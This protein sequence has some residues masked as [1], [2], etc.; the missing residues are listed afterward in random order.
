ML[1]KVT[2][3]EQKNGKLICL[4][5]VPASGKS[6]LI[7]TE[8]LDNYK[9]ACYV[10]LEMSYDVLVERHGETSI[11]QLD[12][13]IGTTTTEEIDALAKDYTVIVIDHIQL[14]TGSKSKISKELKQIAM[15]NEIN[16][17]IL[18]Q[19]NRNNELYGSSTILQDSDQVFFIMKD[20]C[21]LYKN[22][23]GINMKTFSIIHNP[24]NFFDMYL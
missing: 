23:F 19:L 3:S 5:G 10:S 8:I 17:Y 13:F 15:N 4:C 18:S 1:K 7:L 24:Q 14:M 22:R 16:I 12:V 9:N 11:K 6:S 21:L 2:N 20:K